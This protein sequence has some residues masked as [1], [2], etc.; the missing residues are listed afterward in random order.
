MLHQLSGDSTLKKT[1]GWLIAVFC[2]FSLITCRL[3][4]TSD[5]ILAWALSLLSWSF[6]LTHLLG[7]VMRWIE[8]YEPAIEI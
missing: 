7:P 1:L 5:V 2:T 6:T 3:H 4:Y 8:K